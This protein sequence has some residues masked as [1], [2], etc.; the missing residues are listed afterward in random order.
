MKKRMSVIFVLTIFLFSVIFTSCSFINDDTSFLNNSGS[1]NSLST[2]DDTADIPRLNGS[3]ILSHNEDKGYDTLSNTSEKVADNAT[4]KTESKS[5]SSVTHVNSDNVSSSS[6][7]VGTSSSQSS[8]S[9]NVSGSLHVN[10]TRLLDSNNNIIQ[11]RGVSTH[12]LALYSEY[13]NNDLFSQLKNEW[14][15]NVVRLAMYTDEA[16]GY[17]TGGD[18]EELK[19]LIR[20]GVSCAYDNDLYVIIDWHILSDGNP[21]TY[22][23]EA[24][25]FFASMSAEFADMT[26]VL[27]EICNE[28]NGDVSWAD[29]K[30]YAEE[31]IPVIRENSPN[32][33]ILVGTPNWS[34]YV[35][36]AA[37]NPIKNV[38]NIMYT[39]HF[40]AAEHT[41]SLRNSFR[42]AIG[43]GL[44]IFVSEF[45]ISNADGGGLADEYQ[46]NEWLDLLNSYGV[47]YVAW[48]MSNKSET[49]SL[50]RSDCSKTSGFFYE[51]LTASGKWLYR[52]LTG[53]EGNQQPTES[54]VVGNEEDVPSHTNEEQTDTNVSSSEVSSPPSN[55]TSAVGTPDFDAE[56][57]ESWRDGDNY[58]C[59]YV[60]TLYNNTDVDFNS[61]QIEMNFNSEISVVSSWNGN[62]SAE[63]NTLSITSMDYNGRVSAGGT[64]ENIGFIVQGKIG[65]EMQ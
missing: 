47:S 30:S 18:K 65:L 55:P 53:N 1:G 25:E 46:G 49:C 60:L 44:P 3:D 48:N 59:K 63:N 61:W 10:G 28:P 64:V 43:Q 20:N 39:L 21:N 27:Y 51:D 23:N 50:I 33:V 8:V 62:Y 22:K 52:A 32:S 35:E 58:F 45:G 42:T 31:I 11:L 14:G 6:S 56:M 40:Y 26:N 13:I 54:D 7:T 29:V 38:E 36:Q 37:A 5:A 34:Q 4:S 57:V 24:K 15:V 41:D 17:C 19:Q 16:K 9:Q 12:S 2:P